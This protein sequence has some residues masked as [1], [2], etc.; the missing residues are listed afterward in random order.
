MENQAKF[1]NDNIFLASP[2]KSKISDYS[3][4]QNGTEDGIM[5]KG[6]EKNMMN[7]S[8]PLLR[9]KICS[10]VAKTFQG[11]FGIEKLVSQQLTLQ[12]EA[13]IR[14]K[15]PD[16]NASYKNTFKGFLR[17]LKVFAHTIHNFYSF[18][19]TFFRITIKTSRL[20]N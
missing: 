18:L 10:K 6:N 3:I 17:F 15:Y 9:K 2:D 4:N 11:S 20:K 5:L 16:M 12:L 1:I 14:L 19:I 8:K 7:V 13:K